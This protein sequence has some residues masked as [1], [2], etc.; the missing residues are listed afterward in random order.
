M[1]VFACEMQMKKLIIPFLIL[2]LLLSACRSKSTDSVGQKVNIAAGSYTSLDVQEL[3]TMLDSKDFVFINVHIPFAGNIQKTDL[4]IP[5]NELA[6][7]LSQ[8]PADKNAKIVLYCRSGYMSQL[9]AEELVLLGY[10]NVWNL[11]GGMVEWEEAG[12][13]IQE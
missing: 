9:A 8:L 1:M 10:T 12:Y 7:N 3:G 6:Q 13:E 11:E 5:Y 4:S 2:I